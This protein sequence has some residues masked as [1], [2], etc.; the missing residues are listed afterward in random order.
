MTEKTHP[1]ESGSGGPVRSGHPVSSNGNGKALTSVQRPAAPAASG[2]RGFT[3][4][5]FFHALRRW[6]LLAI[7]LGLLIGGGAAALLWWRFEP[8]YEATAWLRIQA[9]SPFIAF[10]MRDGDT[11]TFVQTQVE[12]IRSPMVLGPVVSHPDV[13]ELEDIRNRQEP[14]SWLGQHVRIGSV[15]GSELY[16]LNLR[17]QS[18]DTAAR[19]VN[20]IA[21]E[22]FKLH[23]QQDGERTQTVI[24]L[25]EQERERRSAEV[26]RLRD[27]VRELSR[28]ATGR[29]PFAA[30][31]PADSRGVSVLGDLQGRII[32]SE[33]ERQVLQARLSANVDV[34]EAAVDQ[35]MAADPAAE[36]QR[37]TIAELRA[38]LEAALAEDGSAAPAEITELEERIQQATA[39]LAAIRGEVRTRLEQERIRDRAD[40]PEAMVARAIEESAEVQR[41]RAEAQAREARLQDILAKAAR[42]ENDPR[43][44]RDRAQLDQT[45]EAL[46]QLRES[47]RPQVR[48][49]MEVAVFNR[50]WDEIQ[51]LRREIENRKI[52][53]DALRQRH[54]A[55]LANVQ[56]GTGETLELEFQRAELARAQQVYDQIGDRIV[57]LRTEQRAPTRVTLLQRAQPPQ[58]PVEEMPTKPMLMVLL[59]G[60]SIPYGLAVLWEWF[61]RRVGETEQLSLGPK[62]T[63]IGELSRLPAYARGSSAGF[64]EM[65]ESFRVFM[66]SVESLRTNLL[67]RE[68]FADVRTLAITSAANHEGKTSV[69][70]QLAVSIARASGQPTLLIDGDMRSPDIHAVFDVR[71]EPG[72]AEVLAEQCP[73]EEAI[74]TEWSRQLH[75]LPAGRLRSSPHRLLSNGTARALLERAGER[76]RYV[77]IDTPP[78]L[79]ASEALVVARAADAA[80]LCA[81]RDVSRV[82]QVQRAFDQ[83]LATGSRPLGVV[84]SGVSTRHYA[85]RYGRYA[86]SE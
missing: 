21:D 46:A 70:G 22:Y 8:V 76:Y 77:V 18:P 7:P 2:Q 61:V 15:G 45:R 5:L 75:I 40:V 52:T 6:G 26:S 58:R 86:Y 23:D 47:L 11:R 85:Y 80:L 42:G 24:E 10:P 60:L 20:A 41:L 13:A 49:E 65:G 14:A 59:V 84:L 62:V 44:R 66:E 32:A 50:R 27:A 25:L 28:Q 3:P 37:Q 81:M 71:G 63:V 16:R 43:Y 64:G 31:S 53:E 73:L 51:A 68:D 12:L 29:D 78:V 82:D 56:V 35:A 69:A 72:L 57:H 67:L 55:E 1:G 17:N 33:V 83:L 30:I 54:Q 36:E 4:Q 19:L 79:A 48:T 34:S 39:A 74:V 38:T 9:Q